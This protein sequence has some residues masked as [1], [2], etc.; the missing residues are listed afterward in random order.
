MWKQIWKRFISTSKT[1]PNVANIRIPWP[2]FVAESLLLMLLLFVATTLR[3]MSLPKGG[4]ERAMSGPRQGR[5]KCTEVLGNDMSKRHFRF[6]SS[7]ENTD[8]SIRKANI[9]NHE[10]VAWHG[11]RLLFPNVGSSY[12]QETFLD[13]HATAWFG[14]ISEI[15]SFQ[16]RK[17]GPNVANIRIP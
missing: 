2:P 4:R 9:S 3:I 5:E 12:F 7:S 15:N 14:G 1:G 6:L 11:W 17:I 13:K 16:H 10:P 8:F